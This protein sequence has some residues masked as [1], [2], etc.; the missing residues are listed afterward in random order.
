MIDSMP[1]KLAGDQTIRVSMMLRQ[2][3]RLHGAEGLKIES[4]YGGMKLAPGQDGFGSPQKVAAFDIVKKMMDPRDVEDA[5]FAAEVF[6]K[7][8]VASQGD[9]EPVFGRLRR[10]RNLCL[11]QAPITNIDGMSDDS[12]SVN[13][14]IDDDN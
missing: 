3:Y 11:S 14:G 1:R 12:S 13:E 8:L 2:E 7:D 6:S 4:R 5:F 9:G 10:H